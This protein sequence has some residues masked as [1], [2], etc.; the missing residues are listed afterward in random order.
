MI[1]FT[2]RFKPLDKKIATN[3][4]VEIKFE[5]ESLLNVVEKWNRKENKIIV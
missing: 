1:W 5:I 4:A 2:F 3:L